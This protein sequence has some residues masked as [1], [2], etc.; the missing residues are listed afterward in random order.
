MLAAQ[1]N[2]LSNK[3]SPPLVEHSIAK[4][5]HPWKKTNLSHGL[6]FSAGSYGSG[7]GS[8]FNSSPLSGSCFT[9]IGEGIGNGGTEII[10]IGDSSVSSSSGSS[11]GEGSGIISGCTSISSMNGTSTPLPFQVLNPLGTLN[12]QH[13]YNGTGLPATAMST[14]FSR[15]P[16]VTG[17]ASNYGN[18]EIFCRS[19]TPT[20]SSNLAH[21]QTDCGGNGAIIGDTATC[22][23]TGGLQKLHTTAAIMDV[24]TGV[25]SP[26]NST[27]NIYTHHP[28][29]GASVAPSPY[30]SPTTWHFNMTGGGHHHTHHIKAEIPS[31]VNPVVSPPWWELHSVAAN[32]WLSEVSNVAAANSNQLHSQLSAGYMGGAGAN[33][34][35]SV[36]NCGGGGVGVGVGV[37]GG[38]FGVENFTLGHHPLTASNP[39][40]FFA[41]SPTGQHHFHLPEHSCKT[42]LPT[43]AQ[44]TE[45]S[46]LNVNQ[47]VAVNTFFNRPPSFGAPGSSLSSQR[48]GSTT[49][50]TGSQ[51]RYASRSTCECPN[52]QEAERL[53]PAAAQLRKKNIHSCHVPGCGKVYNKTS[54]LKA[55]LRWHTGERPFVC[56]WLFCGKRFTRSDE[57]QRHLRTH[58]GEKRFAC[59]VCNKRFMRSDHLS[60]HLK[61]HNCPSGSNGSTGNSGSV[62]SG[63]GTG[64]SAVGGAGSGTN[65]AN[66]GN[67]LSSGGTGSG[68]GRGGVNGRTTAGGGTGVINTVSNGTRN[69]KRTIAG[70]SCSDSENSQEDAT[71]LSSPPSTPVTPVTLT[72]V[73][74]L[75]HQH[76]QTHQQTQQQQQQQSQQLRQQR[77]PLHH[78]QQ[79]QQQQQQQQHQPQQQHLHHHHTQQ[80]VQRHIL[81]HHLVIGKKEPQVIS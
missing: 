43:H 16:S 30:D 71:S 33:N 2:K 73:P 19:T 4:S 40:P 69:G 7:F 77:H 75:H 25:T 74:I 56:N 59:T 27:S 15:G 42:M 32:S 6:T 8:S 55:H 66:S 34:I 64:A 49:A 26:T 81:P 65:G 45:L 57:L 38:G 23:G 18:G 67:G 60:K 13:G 3:N 46:H 31:S 47:Q 24:C 36:A 76:H 14:G 28:R 12:H 9:G 58:T 51:R 1:C 48:T 11:S 20:S 21:A 79:Q 39:S 68:R 61:T 22:L 41:A 5:F 10:S 50:S 78:T 70:S 35:N 63:T 17:G 72:P 53:G 80:T 52:C 62:G 44:N 29:V 54:H 37:G